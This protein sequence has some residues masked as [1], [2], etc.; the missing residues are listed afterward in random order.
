M[1]G[2]SYDTYTQPFRSDGLLVGVLA[3][4]GQD[5]QAADRSSQTAFGSG[6]RLRAA[7]D[8]D[9]SGDL[10]DKLR[11]DAM[12]IVLELARQGEPLAVA[13]LA[14]VLGDADRSAE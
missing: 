10:D 7:A 2:S 11:R 12:P 14:K 4:T 1:P 5:L 9:E 8:N 13:C 3:K 6:Q